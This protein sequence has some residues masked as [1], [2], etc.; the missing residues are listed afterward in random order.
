MGVLNNFTPDMGRPGVQEGWQKVTIV[1][2]K[3]DA[4]RDGH[5]RLTLDVET[6]SGYGIKY[7]YAVVM[8]Y[9]SSNRRLT[10]LLMAFHTGLEVRSV[11]ALKGKRG[12][13][14]LWKT[15]GND[16]KD[17]WKVRNL[18]VPEYDGREGYETWYKNPAA[19]PG[20]KQQAAHVAAP[21]EKYNTRYDKHPVPEQFDDDI[22]F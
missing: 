4:T 2:L 19:E 15:P 20:V 6:E 7:A 18:R 16:G 9:D 22:P 3:E 14:Y 21:A 17:Y 12:E 10:E 5:E 8:G 1:G 11:G 13:V